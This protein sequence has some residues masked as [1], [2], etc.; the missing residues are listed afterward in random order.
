MH[1]IRRNKIKQKETGL[2]FKFLTGHWMASPGGFHPFSAP[3]EATLGCF[4]RVRRGFVPLHRCQVSCLVRDPQETVVD[5]V[6]VEVISGNRAQIVH[7][8]RQRSS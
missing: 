4:E 3:A 6:P 8:I 5:V 7:R 1:D 2:H